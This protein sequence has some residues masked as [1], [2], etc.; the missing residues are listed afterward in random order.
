[1][2]LEADGVHMNHKKISRI[3]KKYHLNTK[4]RRK[5][6]YKAVMKKTAEHTVHDNILDRQFKQYIPNTVYCTDITYIPFLGRFIYLSPIKDIASGEIITWN[7]S[8]HIDMELVAQMVK[9]LEQRIHKTIRKNIIIHS[10]QGSHYTSPLYANMIKRL[11]LIQ[12]ISRKGNCIDNAPME[13]FS[14]H[15]KDEIEYEDCKTFQ[16]IKKRI[17]NYMKQGSFLFL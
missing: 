4:I 5:N 16:E 1:M 7:I 15:F 6:P 10:D 11:G 12:S 17:D 14:G 9:Q 13:S 2:K 8:Q 3:M